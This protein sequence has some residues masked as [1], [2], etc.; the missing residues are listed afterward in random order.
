MTPSLVRG[1]RCWYKFRAFQS[2]QLV[3]YHLH[4]QR[5]QYLCLQYVQILRLKMNCRIWNWLARA[6]VCVDWVPPRLSFWFQYFQKKILHLTS[7]FDFN[8][9]IIMDNWS[10]FEAQLMYNVR[11]FMLFWCCNLSEVVCVVDCLWLRVL[12]WLLNGFYHEL[13]VWNLS[14]YVANSKTYDFISIVCTCASFVCTRVHA[15]IKVIHS[16]SIRTRS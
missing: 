5:L 9:P 4:T 14:E 15:F 7:G 1:C 16:C 3:R 13:Y 12:G 2:N 10:N 11:C 6:A 8:L